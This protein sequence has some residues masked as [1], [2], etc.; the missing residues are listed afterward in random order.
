MKKVTYNGDLYTVEE[1]SLAGR[2][3]K[4]SGIGWVDKKECRH[5]IFW[6]LNL[7]FKK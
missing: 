7:I 4:L 5:W 1:K 6:V 2:F 3:Y